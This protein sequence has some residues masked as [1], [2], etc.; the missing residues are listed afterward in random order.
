LK[1]ATQ[2]V[3]N[4]APH[5][6]SPRQ[7]GVGNWK[8]ILKDPKL[9]FDSRSPIDLKDRCVASP[10][11]VPC[12]HP[13]SFRTYF[14]NVYKEHYPNAKT[15]LSSKIRSTL[16]DGRSI[17]EKTCSK[18]C[19]PF[20]EDEDH[21]LK[22]G[23]EKHGTIWATIVKDTVFQEQNRCSTDLCDHFHNTFPELYQAVGYKLRN[24]PKKK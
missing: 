17:F 14:P 24:A 21:A 1:A 13:S 12:S 3:H 11:P 4:S 23:Y 10:F 18:K 8:A 7:W 20:T 6:H 19:R 22:A 16:P 5:A 15:H 9:M 2:Y